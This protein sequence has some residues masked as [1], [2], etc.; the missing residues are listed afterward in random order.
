MPRCPYCTRSFPDWTN[1][2]AVKCSVEYKHPTRGDISEGCQKYFCGW[3]LKGGFRDSTDCHAH[4]RECELSLNRGNYFGRTNLPISEH[5]QVQAPIRKTKIERYLA[6]CD[7]NLSP[8][9]RAAVLEALRDDLKTHGIEQI[10][11]DR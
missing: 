2:F 9:E 10:N 4:V 1:C 8:Q 3:C 5:N 11:I 7:N 6:S